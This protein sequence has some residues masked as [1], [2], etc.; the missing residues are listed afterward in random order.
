M[1]ARKRRGPRISDRPAGA[2]PSVPAAP[3]TPPARPDPATFDLRGCASAA[4]AIGAAA[5]FY[6]WML[7]DPPAASKIGL[8]SAP[9]GLFHG[10]VAALAVGV[11]AAAIVAAVLTGLRALG[12]RDR[13]ALAAGGLYLAGLRSVLGA[14]A[15]AAAPAALVVGLVVLKR[16][17]IR[18]DGFLLVLHAVGL[19][20][21]L[22]LFHQL[23]QYAPGW[24]T[25]IANLEALVAVWL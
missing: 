13:L 25:F 17:E 1:N 10:F 15:L 7:G 18:V 12:V 5:G 4:L 16:R 8:A 6:I 19:G 22:C 14:T 2:S 11:F 9:S 3:L 20:I 24:T 23:P 21:A